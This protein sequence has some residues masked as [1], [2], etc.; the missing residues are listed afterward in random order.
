MLLGLLVAVPAA[1][2][3][4]WTQPFQASR[5]TRYSWYSQAVAANARGDAIVAWQGVN[6]AIEATR[7]TGGHAFSGWER[8]SWADHAADPLAVAVSPRGDMVIAWKLDNG[9][10]GLLYPAG[11]SS[12]VTFDISFAGDCTPSDTGATFDDAGDVTVWW[13]DCSHV[14]SAT[15]PAGGSFGPAQQVPNPDPQDLGT[16]A[17]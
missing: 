12:P 4:T 13:V 7:R 10:Q 11:A 15:R 16:G 17:Y 1:G 5:T 2:A 14:W 6:Q 8:V 9:L 3:A